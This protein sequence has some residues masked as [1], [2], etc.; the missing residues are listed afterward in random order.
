ME[1]EI[2]ERLDAMQEAINKTQKIAVLAGKAM[3]TID[4]VCLLTGLSKPHIYRL[5]CTHTLP[6]YR[7]NGKLIYF[8]R[9]EIENYMRSNRVD[10]VSD[11]ESMASKYI[12][13]GKPST[14]A[15]L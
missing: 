8:D 14:P 4:D 6:Y 10:C 13:T 2:L 12:V 15:S 3:L 1:T 11:A 7:P 5:T 9:K